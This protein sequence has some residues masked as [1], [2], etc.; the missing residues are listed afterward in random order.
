M[1]RI[2]ILGGGGYVGLV[3]ASAFADLGHDVIGIDV[4][5]ARILALSSG[6]SPIY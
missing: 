4:D 6:Q 5:A 2:T 1:A 3:Y